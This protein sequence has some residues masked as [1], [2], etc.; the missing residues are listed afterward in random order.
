MMLLLVYMPPFPRRIKAMTE[1]IRVEDLVI[2]T[3]GAAK[4]VGMKKGMKTTPILK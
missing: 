3:G 2:F 1:R 4:S